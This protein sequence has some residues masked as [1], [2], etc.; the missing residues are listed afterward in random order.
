M[1]RLSGGNQFVWVAEPR[2]AVTAAM[3]ICAALGNNGSEFDKEPQLNVSVSEFFGRKNLHSISDE[4]ARQGWSL[5]YY[6]NIQVVCLSCMTALTKRSK[7]Q[8]N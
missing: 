5:P 3:H 1:K 7:L 2:L 4:G 6:P 8:I